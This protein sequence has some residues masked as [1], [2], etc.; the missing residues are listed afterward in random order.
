M[1]NDRYFYTYFW[2]REDG[3]PY[4][5]GKGTKDRAFVR[6][7]VGNPPSK[8]C[9]LLQE[10][11]SEKDAFEAE[12]FFIEYYGRID[13]G[14]GCLRNLTDG[15]E[16]PSNPSIESRKKMRTAKLGGKRSPESIAKTSASLIGRK[17]PPRSLKH[18]ANL[19]AANRGRNQTPESIAKRV[20]VN[21]GKKRSAE[22]CDRISDACKDRQFSTEHRASLSA[23]AKKK[24]AA[25]RLVKQL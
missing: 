22:T 5:V 18:R 16:G 4:Y 15:G 8:E 19:A 20:S 11:P 12:K 25:R 3:T 24:Y 23:A 2:L 17:K 21:T 9:I 14:T 10:H 1:P 7:R 6:H 13:L